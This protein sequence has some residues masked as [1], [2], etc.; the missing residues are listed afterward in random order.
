MSMPV[1]I[2][3]IAGAGAIAVA[4]SVVMWHASNRSALWNMAFGAALA[5]AVLAAVLL[6]ALLLALATLPR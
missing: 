6:A 1:E 5:A 3:L 2:L 4:A